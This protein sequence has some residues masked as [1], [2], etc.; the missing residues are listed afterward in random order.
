MYLEDLQMEKHF[1]PILNNHTIP[2][3]GGFTGDPKTGKT[4]YASVEEPIMFGV[5]LKTKLFY[6]LY[7]G[8]GNDPTDFF[9]RRKI[10]FPH[11]T[12]ES[13]TNV[14]IT[15]LLM[16]HE[17]HHALI[18]RYSPIMYSAPDLMI[19]TDRHYEA[20]EVLWDIYVHY[21][22]GSTTPVR[23]ELPIDKQ[24]GAEQVDGNTWWNVITNAQ[25]HNAFF[26]HLSYRSGLFGL[27][28]TAEAFS[29]SKVLVHKILGMNISIPSKTSDTKMPPNY[30][31]SGAPANVDYIQDIKLKF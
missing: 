22:N 3:G 2:F 19:E 31:G 24:Y 26:G 10:E 4:Y 17:M 25:G 8:N 12:F 13:Y 14:L 9:N 18:G 11:W 7:N 16:E 23:P 5:H 21:Y 30:D 28:V 27:A 1:D 29:S 20:I 6:S 15:I